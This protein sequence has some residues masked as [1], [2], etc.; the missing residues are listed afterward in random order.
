MSKVEGRL[1]GG[2]GNVNLG[3]SGAKRP[4]AG[5]VT[6]CGGAVTVVSAGVGGCFVGADGGSPLL[7]A[8]SAAA[9]C[10]LV[11]RNGRAG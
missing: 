1:V 2:L 7:S 10:A 5:A 9:S 4:V 11:V 6:V 3:L 8:A